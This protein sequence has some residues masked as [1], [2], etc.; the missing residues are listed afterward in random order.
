MAVRNPSPHDVDRLRCEDIVREV[1]SIPDRIAA[2]QDLKQGQTFDKE[3]AEN[4]LVGLRVQI[5][6]RP[7]DTALRARIERA[8]SKKR[9]A[10]QIL[11]RLAQQEQELVQDR[12]THLSEF[13]RA[14]CSRVVPRPI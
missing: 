3:R 6:N 11:E 4:T 7:D 13:D 2:L 12:K 9:R 14:L 1:D 8:K 5:A 10:E